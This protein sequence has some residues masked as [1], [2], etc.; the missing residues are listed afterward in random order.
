MM[1]RPIAFCTV[2]IILTCL[3]GAPVIA[4]ESFLGS[5]YFST[6]PFRT[7]GVD[8]LETAISH[9]VTF[10]PDAGFNGEVDLFENHTF[11]MGNHLVVADSSVDN[12]FPAIEALLTNGDSSDLVAPIEGYVDT[13]FLLTGAHPESFWA[14]LPLSTA[15]A[16]FAGM[17]LTRIELEP[18]SKMWSDS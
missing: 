4:Q 11:T 12:D 10:G 14:S 2:T 7:Q 16:D 15:P 8:G 13:G 3:T 1:R 5:W 9:E 17:D 6:D 18:V